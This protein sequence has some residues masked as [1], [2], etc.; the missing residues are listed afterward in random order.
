MLADAVTVSYY[1]INWLEIG[2]TVAIVLL[3]VA[4]YLVWRRRRL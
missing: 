2:L 4:A 1:K 3:A